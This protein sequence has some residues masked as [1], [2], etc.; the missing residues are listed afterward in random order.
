MSYYLFVCSGIV[1]MK[2]NFPSVGQRCALLGELF[3]QRFQTLTVQIWIKSLA[4]EKQPTVDDSLLIPSNMKQNLPA[5]YPGSE[6]VCAGTQLFTRGTFHLTLFKIRKADPS[7]FTIRFQNGSILLRF[8]SD[9]RTKIRFF[10]L[11]LVA[12]MHSDSLC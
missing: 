12:L 6:T 1:L 11:T 5:L 8:N 7:P 4:A 9:A 10:S 3:L 2:H